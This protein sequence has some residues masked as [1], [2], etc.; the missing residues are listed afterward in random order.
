MHVKVWIEVFTPE[1]GYQAVA[2]ETWSSGQTPTPFISGPVAG[3]IC[4]EGALL[5]KA[6]AVGWWVDRHGNERGTR[7]NESLA[8]PVVCSVV[9]DAL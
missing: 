3:N 9:Q 7:T 1:F 4:I 6:I 2:T 5:T 8:R